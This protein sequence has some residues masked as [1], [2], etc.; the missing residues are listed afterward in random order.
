MHNTNELEQI[1]IK[2]IIEIVL[3]RFVSIVVITILCGLISFGV[4]RYFLTP[5]YESY[6]TMYVNNGHSSD[7]ESGETKMLT[8]DLQASKQLVPIY[9][10]MIKSDNVLE[11][12]ADE[13]NE[14]TGESY[15][16]AKLK[17]MVE[18]TSLGNT[19]ILKV[20]VRTTEAAVAREIANIVA[21]IAP[22]KIQNFIDRSDVKIIDYAKISTT[23][24]S[25]N[26]R[27][28]TIIGILLGLVLSIS[29][30]LMK[31]LFDVRVKNADD[32]VKRFNYPVLGT[33]PEIVVS[34]DDSAYDS[35]EEDE[36]EIDENNLQNNY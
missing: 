23:P 4:S 36:Y 22:Q 10:E 3:E 12:V 21:E 20:T 7:S 11:A 30:I 1:D 35:S 17:G 15:S 25:P 8:S 18:A 5:K 16:V 29:F 34:Y 14:R 32:L 9:V 31:E 19:E 26:T 24:V 28:N 6:I 2:R 27:N 33:I 13:F